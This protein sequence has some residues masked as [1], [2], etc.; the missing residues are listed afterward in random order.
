MPDFETL[1]FENYVGGAN[2]VVEAVFVPTGSGAPTTVRV[3]LEKIP[4]KLDASAFGAATVIATLDDAD[5]VVAL[6][7]SEGNVLRRFTWANIKATLQT[8]FEGVFVSK[9]AG[10]S[11][12]VKVWVGTQSA[13][14]AIA[15]KDANTLYHIT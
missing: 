9:A 7:E 11:G 8:F 4:G 14:D 15:T 6:D 2:H 12:N 3:E 5:A 10:V 1:P 13:Y